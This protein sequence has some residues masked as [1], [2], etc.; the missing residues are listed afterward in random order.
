MLNM[1]TQPS[2]CILGEKDS[3]CFIVERFDKLKNNQN[4]ILKVVD[5]GNHSLELEKDTIKFIE[6]LKSVTSD[7]NE[8]FIIRLWRNKDLRKSYH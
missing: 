8:F 2:I 1:F 4:L 6:I 3:S 7:I 5:G